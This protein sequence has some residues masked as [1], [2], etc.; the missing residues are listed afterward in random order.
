MKHRSL[1]KQGILAFGFLLLLTHTPL[2]AQRPGPIRCYWNR[3]VHDTTNISQPQLLV[4]PT[5]AYS[6][7]TSWEFGLSSLYVFYAKRDTTNRLS[8]VNGFTFYTLEKQWGV[9]FDHALYSDK[10]HW[11]V[12]GRMRVQSFPLF[13]HGI[14]P[15]S[16]ATY[17]ALVDA[18]HIQIKERVLRKV[19]KN[20]YAG[21]ETDFQRISSVQFLSHHNGISYELPG[22]SKGSANLGIGAGIIYDNRHNVLNVRHGI[23]SEIAV[24][25]YDE[26]WAS[27]YS[28]TSVISDN[29]FYKAINKRDVLAAQMFGQFTNGDVPFNHL[30][31]MGG[32][33]LMRGYYMGRYRDNHLVASQIE[34]RMLPLPFSFTKNGAQAHS[35]VPVLFSAKKQTFI[36]TTLCWQAVPASATC[37]FL[38]RI[39]SPV[40]MWPLP[41][42]ALAS[43]FILAKHFNACCIKQ[44]GQYFMVLPEAC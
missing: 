17:L 4:Y 11:F 16:P 5:L 8:E 42:K 37:F 41:A 29:R 28:F 15:H 39:F 34:Y 27:D 6:P 19:Y 13:Y 12:L 1:Y 18:D 31:L 25:R 40:W 30:A 14:G 22:G 32:E 2:F 26:A 44:T 7:E 36:S 43:I 9:W 33:S 3:L 23:F 21:I 10:N 35:L 38:K 24:L 20:V